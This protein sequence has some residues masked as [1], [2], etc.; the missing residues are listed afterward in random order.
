MINKLSRHSRLGSRSLW[1][2]ALAAHRSRKL[3]S[4]ER[5]AAAKRRSVSPRSKQVDPIAANGAIF[6]DWPKPDVALV[7]SGE[8]DGYL[9][10]CGCAGLEN[11]KGGLRRRFT[12]LKELRD[13]G[14]PLVRHGPAAARRSGPACRPKSKLDFAY[15]ALAK[16]GYAAVGFGETICTWICC[17]S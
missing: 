17:R 7:F 1:P 5:A 16:M 12:L 14:W 9:E 4:A 3:D 10:P 13:K 8:Q 2:F 11:Q 15:R 6:V